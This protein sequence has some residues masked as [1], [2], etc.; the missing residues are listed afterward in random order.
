MDISLTF[1]QVLS[2]PQKVTKQVF[3]K[4]YPQLHMPDTDLMPPTVTVLEKVGRWMDAL[5]YQIVN[6]GA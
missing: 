1:R 4:T 6:F 5:N 2:V 3:G